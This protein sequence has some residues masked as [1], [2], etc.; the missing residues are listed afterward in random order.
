[1]PNFDLIAMKD[2]RRI[3]VQIGINGSTKLS[4]EK[5]AMERMLIWKDADI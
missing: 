2:N 1:M 5:A 3:T 4:H